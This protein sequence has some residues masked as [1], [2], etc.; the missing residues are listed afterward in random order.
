VITEDAGSGS[1]VF[2][3]WAVLV[4]G[5]FSLIVGLLLLTNPLASTL[6]IVQFIGMYWL[7]S[8]VFSL[9]GIFIDK[10]MWGWKLLS[11]IVGILAGLSI[12]NHP[13]WSTLLLPT[14]LVTF[15]GVDGVIIG[16]VGL[17]GAFKGGGW[18]AGILGVLSLL[19]GFFLLG[20]PVI[21]GLA[22]PWVYGVL[23]L[24]GGIAAIIAAFQQRKAEE[25]V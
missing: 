3:W 10:S 12:V 25:A 7:V 8:G 9:I 16:V 14:V 11:G 21:A 15:M 22:L 24:V 5:I 23:G 4:Q 2:P 18:S 6:V 20:S 19:F 13:L 1:W 17:I